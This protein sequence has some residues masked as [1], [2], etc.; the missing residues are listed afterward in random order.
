LG[1]QFDKWELEECSLKVGK[2]AV[3]KMAA[4]LPATVFWGQDGCPLSNCGEGKIMAFGEVSL[5]RSLLP[6]PSL[7]VYRKGKFLTGSLNVNHGGVTLFL[8][9]LFALFLVLATA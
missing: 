7:P 4:F 6:S 2:V 5:R 9:C 3:I 8:L 1:E